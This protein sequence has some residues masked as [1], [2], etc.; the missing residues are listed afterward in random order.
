VVNRP[1]SRA[2][3]VGLAVAIALSVLITAAGTWLFFSGALRSLEQW[4]AIKYVALGL[5]AALAATVWLRRTLSTPAKGDPLWFLFRL[6]GA[7]SLVALAV[8]FLWQGLYPEVP[9]LWDSVGT[10]SALA[11]V[12]VV[13]ALALYRLSRRVRAWRD[14]RET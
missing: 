5:V 11:L 2:A 12:V 4:S 3:T 10:F 7:M 14:T 8:L 1:S 6:C 13:Q 9:P